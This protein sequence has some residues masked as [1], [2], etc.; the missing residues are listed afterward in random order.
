MFKMRQIEMS[1]IHTPHTDGKAAEGH[2]VLV[3]VQQE[4]DGLEDSNVVVVCNVA[5]VCNAV[6]DTD[7][8]VHN[9]LA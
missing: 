5:V 3:G 8:V 4:H 1:L 9:R 7:V 6:E 2:T